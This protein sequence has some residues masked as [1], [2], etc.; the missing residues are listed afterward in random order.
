MYMML[1]SKSRTYQTYHLTK[2]MLKKM[3][4]KV[5][6]SEA[7]KT[8]ILADTDLHFKIMYKNNIHLFPAVR[9]N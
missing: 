1:N 7:M 5:A 4:L 9:R 8:V 2:L 3:K 6:Y